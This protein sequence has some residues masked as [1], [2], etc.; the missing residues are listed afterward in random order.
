[1]LRPAVSTH[2]I[3][4]RDRLVRIVV[5]LVQNNKT[6]AVRVTGPVRA[7]VRAAFAHPRLTAALQTLQM[8]AD[9]LVNR[10]V[11]RWE[12]P[13]HD[14]EGR[15]EWQKSNGSMT[16]RWWIDPDDVLSPTV[17]RALSVLDK[18]YASV[19]RDLVVSG[20]VECAEGV[21]FG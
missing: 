15:Q 7:A 20:E 2:D 13:G 18:Q 14:D 5:L 8:D 4:S 19:P 11:T 16:V 1:M 12:R 10:I 6:E 9:R 3:S 21:R 17:R